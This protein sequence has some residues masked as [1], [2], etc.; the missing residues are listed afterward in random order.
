MCLTDLECIHFYNKYS[1]W[2]LGSAYFSASETVDLLLIMSALWFC[3]IFLLFYI[4][5]AVYKCCPS[6][7]THCA[8]EGSYC[9]SA[10]LISY[11]HDA[12]QVYGYETSSGTKACSNSEFTD[13]LHG[14]GKEC[15]G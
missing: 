2:D 11:G 8:S 14:V 12:Y 13:P 9:Y 3:R 15:C 4:L 7:Y 5:F 6:G 1:L 10:G